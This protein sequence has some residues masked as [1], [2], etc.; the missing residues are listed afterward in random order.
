MAKR[1]AGSKKTLVRGIPT[2]EHR[3]KNQNLENI[4]K[5]NFELNTMH[6]SQ[7]INQVQLPL[8]QFITIQFLKFHAESFYLFTLFWVLRL[9]SF[10]RVF[11]FQSTVVLLGSTEEDLLTSNVNVVITSNHMIPSR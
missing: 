8:N 3:F 1:L 6:I 2:T 4:L 9:V 5:S 11:Y 10:A 7:A